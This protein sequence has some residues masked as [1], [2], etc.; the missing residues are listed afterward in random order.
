MLTGR[1][2]FVDKDPLAM[3]GAHVSRDPPPFSEVAPNLQLPPGLEAV[4]QLGLAKVSAERITTAIDYMRKLDEVS[5][6]AGY[7]LHIAPRASSNLSIPTGPHPAPTPPAGFMMTP[8]PFART[9]TPLSYTPM[10]ATPA[11]LGVATTQSVDS[12]PAAARRVSFADLKEPLPRSM[13]KAGLAIIIAAIVGALYFFVFHKSGGK[14]GQVKPPIGVRM[15][16]AVDDGT[17]RKAAL[18]DLESGKTC[19]DRKAAIATLVELGPDDAA[20]AAIKKARYRMRGGVLGVGDSNTNACLKTDAER[21][22]MTFGAN[23]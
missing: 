20:I 3:L 22:L 18:H 4:I 2:P 13:K 12:L 14:P 17:R 5:R 9:A 10:P 7:E 6:A 19:A 15:P 16:N 1:A 21:A 8:T 23:K 11:E